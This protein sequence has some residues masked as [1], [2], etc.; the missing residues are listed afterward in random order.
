MSS[1]T[2]SSPSRGDI[3]VIVPAHNARGTLRAALEALL[4]QRF[5]RSFELI[6]VDDCSTDDTAAIAEELGARVV[7]TP[8]QGGPAA[9]R[10]AGVAA[11]SASLLAFTDADCEP[12]PDWLRH[13]VAALE[14]GAEIVT[15]P[16]EP[17]RTPG[18]FDRTLSVRGPS[19]LFE[20]ANLF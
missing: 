2:R 5:D 10:N 13:G 8:R 6:V 15:G 9:A 11:T 7:R 20:S 14:A 18:P 4:A 19:P 12:A 16:I 17:V 1:T 3:A